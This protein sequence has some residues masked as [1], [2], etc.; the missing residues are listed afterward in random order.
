MRR[1]AWLNWLN[2]YLPSKTKQYFTSLPPVKGS[3]HPLELVAFLISNSTFSPESF[4]EL[5]SPIRLPNARLF[6]RPAK[7][8]RRVCCL[9][10]FV[11]LCVF[12]LT[13]NWSPYKLCGL[14]YCSLINTGTGT[15]PLF[16]AVV[17]G[18]CLDV[19]FFAE[20]SSVASTSLSSCS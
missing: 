6:A 13:Q 11:S 18:K 2:T 1:T 17:L 12:F 7:C 9:L 8:Y 10:R 3:S 20:F 14:I 15:S 5:G 16:T 4:F 19:G